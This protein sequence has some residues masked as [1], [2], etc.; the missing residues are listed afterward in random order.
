MATFE[1]L[2]ERTSRTF[3]L[4]VPLLPSP[5]R[6]QVGLAYLLLRIADTLEDAER[7]A[8]ERRVEEL[9]AFAQLV[10]H[11]EPAKAEAFRDR[12]AADAPSEH[13]GYRELLAHTAPVIA[14][15]DALPVAPRSVVVKHVLMT[16]E[17]MASTVERMGGDGR[18][19]LRSLE[20]LRRY[21]YVVAGLV[22]ELLT[23]LFLI[24][25]PSLSRAASLLRKR[26]REFGEGLQLTNILKDSDEDAEQG[27]RYLPAG[28]NRPAVFS[29]ARAD[30]DSAVAFVNALFEH[31]APKGIW[32]FAALPLR[33][34]QATLALVEVKGASAKLSRERVAEM[35]AALQA[36]ATP[37]A[38]LSA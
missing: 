37:A 7:W 10:Q 30:L 35:M 31:G 1:E 12:M 32:A 26:A 21:C 11:R 16:V 2:L 18:L 36:A 3:A 19:A 8:G 17:G 4:A 20:E 38:F 28:V 15:L 14:A 29:L 24:S 9:L 5:I 25:A 33:L 6:E 22:G 34:A 13:A 23:E 27:R